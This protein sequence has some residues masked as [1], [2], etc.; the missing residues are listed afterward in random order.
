MKLKLILCLGLIAVH[1]VAE[2]RA[3]RVW[4]QSELMNAAD[5][6]VVG[7][8]VAVK[9][10]N[11]TDSLGFYGPFSVFHGVETTFAVSD[12]I[13]GKPG[14]DHIVLHH[15]REEF[16]RSVP[17]G[18]GFVSFT[19]GATNQYLLFLKSDGTNRY[20]PAAGQVD[21]CLSIKPF[22]DF[23]KVGAFQSSIAAE[24]P[25]QNEF[26][27]ALTAQITSALTQC[28]TIKPGMTRADLLKVFTLEGGISTAN[29]QTFI[30]RRCPYIKVD[31]DF[32]LSSPTQPV[33]ETRLTDAVSKISK[34]YLDWIIMD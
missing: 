12:V 26:D 19:P 23:P 3:V 2:A 31:V 15:Y 28:Q 34:P 24:L 16:A 4:S 14:T 1:A 8:P 5:L 32:I 13:K 6:V 29:H 11:E 30:Y 10:L 7:Q 9:M 25:D 22:P 21:A 20:A 33:L 17:N 27:K 18:P